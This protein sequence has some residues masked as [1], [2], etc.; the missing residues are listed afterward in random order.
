MA[1]VAVTVAARTAGRRTTGGA[2]PD[3]EG[4]AGGTASDT[5][6]VAEGPGDV[7]GGTDGGCISALSSEWISG[8]GPSER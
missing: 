7:A 4:M 3:V 8:P 2:A 1:A 6:G 5:G